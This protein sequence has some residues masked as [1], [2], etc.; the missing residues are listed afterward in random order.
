MLTDSLLRAARE[1]GATEAEAIAARQESTSIDVRGG[2]LEQ[3]DRAESLDLGL[4]VLIGG[5][6]A[7]VTSSDP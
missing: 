1:A 6:Q 7:I 5:R 3:A 2:R 4:R